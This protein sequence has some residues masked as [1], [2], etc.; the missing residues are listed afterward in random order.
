MIFL[1]CLLSL[2][3]IQLLPS[4]Q[5]LPSGQEVVDAYVNAK[6]GAELLKKTTSYRMLVEIRLDGK[7]T[8]DSEIMQSG[9]CH[10]TIHTLPDESK[11]SHGTDGR[12]AWITDKEGVAYPL[13][14]SQRR[15]YLRHNTTVHEALEW[16]NQFHEIQ[17]VGTQQINGKAT[18]E[19]QFK[20]AKGHTIVRFFEVDSGL[21]VREVQQLDVP[22]TQSISDLSDYRRVDGVLVSHRRTVQVENQTTEYIVHHSENN[23][24]FT[25]DQF[26][27]P[28][29]TR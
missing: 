7:K 19:V 1:M 6:G 28:D 23:V 14:G 3:S 2:P 9:R 22:G 15:D 17:C 16:P 24:T 4:S 29:F 26:V 25:A 10:L 11:L 27:A 12:I 13:E 18:Y 20:P 5:Q 21:F 8:A